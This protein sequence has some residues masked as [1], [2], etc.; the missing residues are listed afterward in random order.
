[1]KTI[2]DRVKELRA[3]LNLSQTEFGQK[4]NKKQTT[5]AGYENNTK[6]VIERTLKDICRVFNVSYAWLVDGVGPMYSD[7]DAYLKEKIDIIME[8]ENEFHK[9]LVKQT[10]DLTDDELTLLYKIIKNL[11][12]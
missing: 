9:N 6:T 12:K 11:T 2:G 7:N 10:L 8:G 4:I 1:M 5:V 3:S